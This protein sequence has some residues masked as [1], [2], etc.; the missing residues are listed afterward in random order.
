[1]KLLRTHRDADAVRSIRSRRS[2][3]R[4]ARRTGSGRIWSRKSATRRS[5]MTAVFAI[6]PISVSET[7][8]PPQRLRRLHGTEVPE[9]PSAPKR[10]N[11]CAVP[12]AKD[13]DAHR[14][15][16]R[17]AREGA[18]ERTAQASRRRHARGHEPPQDFLAEDQ[19]DQGR[20][21]SLLREDLAVHPSGHRQPAAGH[22]A[23]AER[24]R[25]AVLLSASC[26][27]A[28]PV[29]RAH[30][31]AAER[32]CA[33][34]ADRRIAEDAALHGAAGVDLDGSVVFDD[35]RSGLGR[36]GCDRS[37]SAAGRDVLADP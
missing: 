31:D 2:C 17:C 24:R 16:T 36:S 23:T 7:T 14:R 3:R 37:R 30:R 4:K 32:R 1:M 28:R 22:E 8:R 19:E 35:G 18:Q 6:L 12:S 29:R 11:S 34:A 13:I 26:A 25:R 5:P 15:A 33:G 10:A 9:V 27:G 21:D 20:S